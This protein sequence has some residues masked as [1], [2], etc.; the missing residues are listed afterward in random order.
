MAHY[1]KVLNEYEP[2]KE[3]IYQE[4]NNFFENPRMV[5]QKDVEGLSMYM[6][7]TQCLL[8]N[9]YRYLIALVMED[10]NEIGHFEYL[11]NL[12]WV[13]FQ[14]RTLTEKFEVPVHSYTPRRGTG[15]DTPIERQNINQKASDYSCEKFDTC[16]VTLLHTKEGPNQY[17]NKGS[18]IT[19]L[20]T[21]QTVISFK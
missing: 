4:I 1:G 10:K 11:D 21:Y 15:I 18:I 3:D 9:E 2:E 6:C 19:A 17:Q 7:K 5:K 13:S 16:V 12:L 14:T 20:E 8:T